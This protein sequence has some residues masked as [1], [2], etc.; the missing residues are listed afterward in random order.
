V[1]VILFIISAIYGTIILIRNLLFDYGI[2]KSTTYNIPIICV[3][4]LSMGGTGK[5]PH[6]MYIAKFLSNRYKVGILSRG[7]GR[8]SSGFS[9]V[10][11]DSSVSKIG[12]EPLQIKQN[13]PYCIIAVN[14]DRNIGV[15]KII[16]DHPKI[17]VILLDDGFQHRKI[18]AGLNILV[19]PFYYPYTNN[20][21]T[22]LGTLR[23]HINE[24]KRADIILISKTPEKTKQDEKNRILKKLNLLEHQEEYFSSVRY[25]KYKSL[26][27]NTEINNEHE[28]SITLVCGIANP[29]PLVDHLQ[30]QGKKIN[31]I[32]FTDHYN[33][34]LKDIEKILSVHKHNKS[35]KKLILTT[36]KDAVKLKRFLP[37][38]NQEH[39]YYI[40]IKVVLNKNDKFEKQLLNYVKRN[41]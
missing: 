28:Y 10:E 33:Y 4:N 13:C 29:N 26:K 9:Y 41:K 25:Q 11:L 31:L 3:G 40:P 8:K 35:T 12:D 39:I 14:E 17:D 20:K 38:L 16:S 6:I 2:L 27:D 23:E 5:T 30:S 36:E 21:L 37:N 32:K 19:T 22:P 18:K 15:K 34:T 1:R 7:Y 24:A